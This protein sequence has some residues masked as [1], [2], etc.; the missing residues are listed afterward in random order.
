MS[1]FLDRL[2][3]KSFQK[4][5]PDCREYWGRYEGVL[6]II[7]NGVLFIIKGVVGLLSG[8]IAVL[9]DAVHTLSDIGSSLGVFFGFKMAYRPADCEH[10][11]GHG[12]M[13][14]IAT[15]GVSFLLLLTGIEFVRSSVKAITD[16]REVERSLFFVGA[17]I[18]SIFVK[19]IMSRVSFFLGKKIRSETLKADGWHHRSDAISSVLV[20]FTFF[21]PRIDGYLGI[22]VA[23]FILWSGITIAKKAVSVLIGEHPSSEFLEELKT[24]VKS[25]DFVEGLHDIIINNYEGTKILS[26]HV[27][28]DSRLTFEKAHYY[29]EMVEEKL[30]EA[31]HVKSVVHIDPVDKT[32]SLLRE[33]HATVTPLLE[34][35]DFVDSFHDLRKI[36]K[37]RISVL[38]DLSTKRAVSR[39]EE[40]A[41]RETLLRE[42]NQ[43]FPAV[44]NVIM[45]VEPL[46]SY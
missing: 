18:A 17:V 25:F 20:L 8:S 36:G 37:K 41:V 22:A 24:F 40:E 30:D 39:R 1:A 23:L 45:K 5:P 21:I 7:L 16:G 34:R 27:E 31:F 29:S 46:F 33:I 19:E 13:E 26:L 6:S 4:H 38:L 44:K 12:R 42:L 9:A 43:A 14:H 11:Y 15:L 3:R 10:P 35:F 28:L 32:D 2:Y